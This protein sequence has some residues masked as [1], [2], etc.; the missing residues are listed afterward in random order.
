MQHFRA[1]LKTNRL[2]VD[3]VKFEDER[4]VRLIGGYGDVKR[5]AA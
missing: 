5:G 2:P 1:E 3:I 4:T